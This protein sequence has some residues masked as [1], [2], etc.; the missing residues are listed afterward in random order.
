MQALPN[1]PF[2][3]GW[4]AHGAMADMAWHWCRCTAD[5]R[6]SAVGE[7]EVFAVFD[8][9]DARGHLTLKAA[10][11]RNNRKYG[12]RYSLANVHRLRVVWLA[13]VNI[14]VADQPAP[15]CP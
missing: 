8:C 15:C 13:K 10:S 3:A 2:T 4:T 1:D 9:P 7:E 6:Q 5:G 14:S 11:D 12:I